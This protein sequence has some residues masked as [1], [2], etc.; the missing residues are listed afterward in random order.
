MPPLP[1]AESQGEVVPLMPL[2]GV[3]RCFQ[4]IPCEEIPGR[5]CEKCLKAGRECSYAPVAATQ[6]SQT[7]SPRD[8]GGDI[9]DFRDPASGP[10]VTQTG[11]A[12]DATRWL[13]PPS[14]QTSLPDYM[15]ASSLPP[16]VAAS[17]GHLEDFQQPPQ[18]YSTY[19]TGHPQHHA[20]IFDN[21]APWHVLVHESSYYNTPSGQSPFS[22]SIPNPTGGSVTSYM[23]ESNNYVRAA[24]NRYVPSSVLGLVIVLT[25]Y[26][27][28]PAITVG[29]LS[30]APLVAHAV[31][32][33]IRTGMKPAARVW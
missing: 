6:E 13:P 26:L 9:L 29:G 11:T 17:L 28:G 33:I 16:A 7:P 14:N 21:S 19:G 1:S 12:N 31:S 25:T 5:T 20:S 4:C 10:Q 30:C 18:F 22:P 27:M 23:Y 15:N 8:D 3:E 2:H 24:E 32:R